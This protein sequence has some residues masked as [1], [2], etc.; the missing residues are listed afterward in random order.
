MALTQISDVVVPQVFTPYTQQLTEQKARMVQSGAA[1]RDSRLDQ[2]LAGGGLTF[3]Q[4][5]WK[6]LADD[7]DVVSTDAESDITPVKTGSATEIQVRLSRNQAWKSADL[8]AELAGSDP[9]ESVAQRVAYYWARR[10]QAA[11]V[12]S[13]TGV[14]NDNEAAPAGTEHVINDLTNDV[15]G[16]GFIDGVTNFTAEALIDATATMG[17]S[18]DQLALMMVH[19]RVY[20]R[21]Q[22]LN[23]I[24]FIPDSRG[25]IDI[26]TFQ[27]KEVVVDDALPS[28][29]ANIF[30]TWLFGSGAVLVGM[31]VP[32]I[33]DEVYRLPLQGAGAGTESL[34]S[35]RQWIIH[36]SGHRFAVASPAAGGPS[37]LTTAGNLAHADSWVRV[38]PERKQI[39]IARLITREA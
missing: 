20:A 7:A 19:S 24:D 3:N 31:G 5:S 17:D 37:N 4:P 38:F 35:R 22:K 9:Q 39:K 1:V 27:G 10:M 33:A 14:F 18:L 25:E 11:F 2:D 6:D 32:D 36:P 30:E 26:A 13:L 29:S 23:L 8:S 12:A 21:M 15:S 34:I 28:P 16:G